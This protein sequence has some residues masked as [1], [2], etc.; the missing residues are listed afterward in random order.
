MDELST[1]EE[2]LVRLMDPDD[3]ITA[4]FDVVL[5]DHQVMDRTTPRVYITFKRV[6]LVYDTA[7]ESYGLDSIQ[8]DMVGEPPR[9]NVIQS[10]LEPR[11]L[12]ANEDQENFRRM[13][14]SEALFRLSIL[15]ERQVP[16]DM[17]LRN[18]ALVQKS[19]QTWALGVMIRN[20]Q[21]RQQNEA[22]LTHMLKDSFIMF[23]S[24]TV[25]TFSIITLTFFLMRLLLVP[26]LPDLIGTILDVMYGIV[27]IIMGAW[28]YTTV[29]KTM[30]KYQA[31]YN[32]YM[33]DRS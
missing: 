12:Y 25:L 11:Y 22:L 31:L 6:F 4:S 15:E 5:L 17:L 9:F 3:S 28:L 24:R 20:Q 32:S 8:I 1:I 14:S 29:N 13:R 27:I 10:L 33:L 23:N 18:G 2:N 16:K 19:Y 26:V 30:Q 21:A 7:I